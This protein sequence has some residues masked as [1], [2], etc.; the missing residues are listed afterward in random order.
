MPNGIVQKVRYQTL[1][2]HWISEDGCV[3]E[4]CFE[5]E[6]CAHYVR[7]RIVGSILSDE[8]EVDRLAHNDAGV[9]AGEDQQ[10]LNEGFRTLDAGPHVLGHAHELFVGRIALRQ[11]DI[12][13]GAHHR[14]RDHGLPNIKDPTP[15]TGYTPDHGFG[16]DSSEMPTA[17]KA[18]PT[19]Q[20]AAAA[21]RSLLDAEI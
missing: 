8:L 10:G 13:C 11:R 4:F 6:P 7:A 18:D 20:R 5:R 21:C 14:L 15:Q 9:P 17:G 2:Q 1:E 19:Y 16:L 12:D 3:L